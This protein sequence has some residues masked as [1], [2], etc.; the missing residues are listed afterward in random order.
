MG[1]ISSHHNT[2]IIMEE[3]KTIELTADQ[4]NTLIDAMELKI[5]LFSECTNGGLPYGIKNEIPKL[6]TLADYLKSI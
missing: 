3:I 5:N 1:V 6:Q 2:N 4:I